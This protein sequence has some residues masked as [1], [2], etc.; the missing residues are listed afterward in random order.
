[1]KIIH[2]FAAI[3]Y[4]TCCFAA[5]FQIKASAY[6]DPG[7][8]MMI[9]QLVAG[10]FISLGVVFGIWR[11][12]IIGFF[13]KTGDNRRVQKEEK[14]REK[15]DIERFNDAEKELVV[16]AE[17]ASYY[18]YFERYL[19]Y[20]LENSGI[21]IHYLTSDIKDPVFEIENP[22]FEA[23]FCSARSLVSVLMKL[24]CKVMLMTMPDLETFHYKRSLVDKN[25]EYIYAH[26]GQ[27]SFHSS[28]SKTAL[29]NY[30]T[31]FC[32]SKN[33]NEEIRAAE[34]VYGLKEKKLV[35]VGYGLLD[36]LTEKYEAMTVADKAHKTEPVKPQILIAPSWQKD[37]LLDFCLN[38]L[39]EELF[40]L[41]AKIIIRPHPEYIKRYPARMTEIKET[42]KEKL[43]E[44]FEIHSDITSNSVVYESDVVI[45]DWSSIAQEFSFA[46]KKPSLFINTPMKVMNPEW[47]KL[48]IE[49]MDIWIRSRIGASL[50]PEALGGAADAVRGMLK[51]KDKYRDD[52]EKIIAEYMYNPGHAGEAGGK[53]IIEQITAR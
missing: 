40:T 49:P 16:Y 24:S 12:K 19:N 37:N 26:H 39:M 30:D 47:E 1:M 18:R 13:K 44:N 14:P 20:I 29:D 43:S 48:G 8:T 32:Y 38:P 21:T 51:N 27:N 33:H 34:R 7:T 3:I 28:M 2:K 41:D 25:I 5:F 31:I 42:Y 46:T 4:F 53:Y 9:T 35:N 36:T 6:I 10:A 17:S 15:K 50:D 52:I 11:R 23:Y 22:R 45:T